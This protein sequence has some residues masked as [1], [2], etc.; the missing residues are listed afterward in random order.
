MKLLNS[1]YL[2]PFGLT[3]YSITLFFSI[4]SQFIGGEKMM[5]TF[6][7][8]CII[9][10]IVLPPIYFVSNRLLRNALRSNNKNRLIWIILITIIALPILFIL[11]IYAFSFM[12]TMHVFGDSTLISN[13]LASSRIMYSRV[14]LFFLQTV[15]VFFSFSFFSEYNRLSNEKNEL[16]IKNINTQ[17]AYLEEQLKALR[18]QI[19]PHSMFNILNHIHILMEENV[20]LASKLLINFSEV[21][22][23]QL[24][25]CNNQ[26]IPLKK[27]VQY[28]KDYIAVEKIRWEDNIVVEY[29]EK[30]TNNTIEINPL[31][32]I[33]F[34]ENAFKY[35]GKN[36]LHKGVIKI[37]ITQTNNTLAFSVENTMADVDMTTT[38]GGIGIENVRKRLEILYS[39]N[40]TLDIEHVD[41]LYRVYLLINI[42]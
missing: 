35:V 3:L 18:D 28:L 10:L 2:K 25:D 19:N 7:I 16:E 32:F 39:G 41:N 24:Y 5:E 14:I 34:V 9:T 11:A 8:L 29:S 23:Y 27:E 21:L 4:W 30:I 42:S 36:S 15:V 40:F 1:K 38:R 33:P 37:D 22:R 31:L 6:F 26:F 12:E 17:K 13:Y 20:E